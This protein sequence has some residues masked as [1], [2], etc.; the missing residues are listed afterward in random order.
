MDFGHSLMAKETPAEELQLFARRGLL[1]SV[2]ST[3]TG[4]TGTTI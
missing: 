4:A 2:K 3:T 1:R